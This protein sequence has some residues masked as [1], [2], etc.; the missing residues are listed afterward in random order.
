VRGGER[1]N[2]PP[3]ATI[4]LLRHT[5]LLLPRAGKALSFGDLVRG[6]APF[7]ESYPK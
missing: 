4:R 5:V 7:N 3:T 2:L 1:G 6:S